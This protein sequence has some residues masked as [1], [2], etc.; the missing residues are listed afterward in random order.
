M[1]W[2]KKTNYD[3][4]VSLVD[5]LTREYLRFCE[6]Y[7]KEITV[8][9]GDGI[10]EMFRYCMCE[11]LDLPSQ[12]YVKLAEKLQQELVSSFKSIL[13]AYGVSHFPEDSRQGV[14][15]AC[16]HSIEMSRERAGL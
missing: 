10:V 1:L 12:G 5:S 7:I 8:N 2:R 14:L 4:D 11:A 16:V 6:K 3:K 15:E 9:T 13:S